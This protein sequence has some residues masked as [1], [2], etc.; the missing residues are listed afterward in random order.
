M[1]KTTLG[2]LSIYFLLIFCSNNSNLYSKPWTKEEKEDMNNYIASLSFEPIADSCSKLNSKYRHLPIMLRKQI[3]M[4]SIARG[5]KLFDGGAQHE[6]SSVDGDEIIHYGSA[7]NAG[8][9]TQ[10]IDKYYIRK[11]KSDAKSQINMLSKSQ[12]EQICAKALH[13]MGG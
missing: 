6:Y 3:D 7:G 5:K 12:L 10:T 8:G 9:Y 11:Y 13:S 2:I 4:H 1:K